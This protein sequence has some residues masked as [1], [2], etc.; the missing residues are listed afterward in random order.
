VRASSEDF[1]AIEVL[2]DEFYLDELV[3]ALKGKYAEKLELLQVELVSGEYANSILYGDKERALE[4]LENIIENAL[5]YGDG[6]PIYLDFTQ[7]EGAQLITVS[8]TGS[9]LPA[10][11]A[12]H[13]FE[14]FWR[15]SNAQGQPGN[16]L[17]LFIVRQIMHQMEGDA[18]ATP[19]DNQ[20]QITLV[21]KLL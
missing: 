18:Y 3:A 15:G 11:E 1:L 5:K 20:M 21:F 14:S 13:V 19:A 7:E 10:Q 4:A 8:N 6:A 17:G 16:G 9:T 12:V 2:N